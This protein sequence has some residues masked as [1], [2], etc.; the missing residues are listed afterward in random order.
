NFDWALFKRFTIKEQVGFEFRAEAFNVFNHTQWGNIAG[1]SGSAGGV[2]N[3][4]L[5]SN[6]FLHV[7]SAHNA[8]ILQLGAKFFF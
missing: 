8:R 3:N 2:G 4:T 6:G 1:D 7:S 5:G